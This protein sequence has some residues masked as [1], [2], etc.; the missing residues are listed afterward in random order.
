MTSLPT[1]VPAS[2]PAGLGVTVLVAGTITELPTTTGMLPEQFFKVKV[3]VRFEVIG[4][5]VKSTILP[6]I[7]VADTDTEAAKRAARKSRVFMGFT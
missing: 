6:V 2:R 7:T 1:S 5:P 4:C 3:T